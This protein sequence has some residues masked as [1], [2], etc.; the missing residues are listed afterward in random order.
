MDVYNELRDVESEIES[1]GPLSGLESPDGMLRALD[2]M[3][4]AGDGEGG[5]GGG[6]AMAALPVGPA[7]A[8]DSTFWR[9]CV[10]C[11]LFGGLM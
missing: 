7:Y 8:T 9:H 4:A 11:V 3:S 2:G 10:A 5:G 1:N 6:D